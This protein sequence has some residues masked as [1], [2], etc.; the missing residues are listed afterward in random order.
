MCTEATVMYNVVCVYA[1]YGNMSF[2]RILEGAYQ[3]THVL[4]VLV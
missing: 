1:L 3:K 4:S 2:V